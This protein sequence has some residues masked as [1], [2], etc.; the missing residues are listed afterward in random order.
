ML[1]V[2]SMA[3]RSAAWG[4]LLLVQA[5]GAGVPPK[6]SAAPGAAEP[7]SGPSEPANV[8]FPAPP[9]PD[10]RVFRMA[11]MLGPHAEVDE[12][13]RRPVEPK[14]RYSRCGAEVLA[15]TPFFEGKSVPETMRQPY[16]EVRM[17]ARNDYEELEG[18]GQG[19][20][21][22]HLGLRTR[23]GWFWLEELARTHA[24][25]MGSHHEWIAVEAMRF[26]DVNAGE[27][28]LFELRFAWHLSDDDRGTDE[29]VHVKKSQLVVCGLTKAG[30][31]RCTGPTP[32][33]ESGGVKRISSAAIV[34]SLEWKVDVRYGPTGVELALPAGASGAGVPPVLVGAHPLDFDAAASR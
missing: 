8:A 22:F 13:C 10:V 18:P 25:A 11:T 24:P 6:R 16:V 12:I 20:T 2:S 19:S 33:A 3:C 31:P 34:S 14:P 21:V 7:L 17:V 26:V 32:V 4:V 29:N 28:P 30:Q 23:D 9:E 5:C 27:P 1:R 15:S